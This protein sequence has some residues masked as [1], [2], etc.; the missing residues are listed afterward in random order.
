[1]AEDAGGLSGVDAATL[2]PMVRTLLGEPAAVVAEGWSCRSL[3]DVVAA[4]AELWPLQLGL[5][6]EARALLPAIG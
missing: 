4:W 2:A 3:E 6:E 1:M 5:A